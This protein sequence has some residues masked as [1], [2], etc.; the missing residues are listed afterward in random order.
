MSSRTPK[1]ARVKTINNWALEH[2]LREPQQQQKWEAIEIEGHYH[3]LTDM[4]QVM[5][6][7]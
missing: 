6:S 5:V 3:Y 1:E 4:K 7:S 2:T